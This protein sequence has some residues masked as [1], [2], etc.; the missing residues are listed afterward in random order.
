M[1]NA[2][3]EPVKYRKKLKLTSNIHNLSDL[4]LNFVAKKLASSNNGKSFAPE[5]LASFYNDTVDNNYFMIDVDAHRV[6]SMIKNA[7]NAARSEFDK[8]QYDL[9][10]HIAGYQRD[11]LPEHMLCAMTINKVGWGNAKSIDNDK[12][13]DY[14]KETQATDNE[15]DDLDALYP[16]GMD[17]LLRY[18]LSFRIWCVKNY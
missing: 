17:W 15:D 9:G 4:S 14:I 1:N 10:V 2:N 5:E 18:N 8:V 3:K 16:V 13:I 6:S 12:L 11:A 7:L